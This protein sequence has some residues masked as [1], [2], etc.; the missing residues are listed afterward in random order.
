MEKNKSFKNKLLPLKMS[1]GRLG[2]SFDNPTKDVQQNAEK[3]SFNV[4]KE[5]FFFEKDF[6]QIF[7]IDT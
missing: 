5:W 1:F 3:T 6:L 4:W 2:L 7:P